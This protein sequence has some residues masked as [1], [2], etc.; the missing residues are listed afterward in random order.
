MMSRP[1][2]EWY[3]E[4]GP[5]LNEVVSS[6]LTELGYAEEE[7]KHLNML[8][9]D[10]KR[11]NM[12]QIPPSLINPIKELHPDPPLYPDLPAPSEPFQQ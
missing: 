10:G 8:C 2:T 3:I 9:S 6:A 7:V 4:T 11:R 5:A 1:Q 12:W